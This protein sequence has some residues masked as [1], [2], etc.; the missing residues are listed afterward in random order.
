MT[1]AVLAMW[2]V[3]L[4]GGAFRPQT[5]RGSLP[6]GARVGQLA[7]NFTL[8]DTEGRQVSLSDYRGKAVFLNFWASWC[9][10][11]RMEMP[12]LQ[13]LT[14]A[15]PPDTAVLTVNATWSELA[16]EKALAFLQDQGYTFATV[17]DPAGETEKAY[18]VYS[19]PTSL[20]VDRE[21][22]VRARI[23]GPLTF[24]AMLGYL[25]EAGR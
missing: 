22:V 11:C 8:T 18:Q 20:F 24:G 1:Y 17:L 25:K 14:A 16:P 2:A 7:P 4:I 6:S 21:G 19:F 13:R 9:G 15:L 10:P 3:L 12:E 5:A 23:A